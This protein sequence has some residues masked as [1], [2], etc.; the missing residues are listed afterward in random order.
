[1]T[2][3]W[4]R[5]FVF[6]LTMMVI[7]KLPFYTHLKTQR[8]GRKKER[9]KW[10]KTVDVDKKRSKTCPLSSSPLFTQN[11]LKRPVYFGHVLEYQSRLNCGDR[12]MDR[13]SFLY[14]SYFLD[15]TTDSHNTSSVG[16]PSASIQYFQAS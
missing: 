7:I 13:R 12:Q 11:Q 1:M 16:V 6:R 9:N 3:P 4:E 5:K 10:K 15:I 8:K 14:L 2:D